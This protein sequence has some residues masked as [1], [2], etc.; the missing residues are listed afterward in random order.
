M[1][2]FSGFC[3]QQEEQLFDFWLDNSAYTVVGFSY[4][5]IK[6]FE[7][8][9]N[10]KSRVDRLI[11]LSP[12]FFNDKDSKYKKMQLLYFTKD[13]NAYIENFLANAKKGSSLNLEP[14]FKEGSKDELK[15]LL[16]YNWDIEKL[17]KLKSKGLTIEVILGGKDLIIDANR[18]KEFFE[19]FATVY[20]IKDANHFLKKENN[21]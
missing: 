15:E 18:A 4:G 9:L 8:A 21:L 17:K 5:A 20:F 12:A 7:Y 6:A 10:S 2:Y 1:N 19:E 13:K 3:L 14:F 11:L 16:Y